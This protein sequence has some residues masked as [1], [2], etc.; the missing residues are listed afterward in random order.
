M[1]TLS[2]S[3]LCFPFVARVLSIPH[4]WT[5]Q[6]VHETIV[7]STSLHFVVSHSLVKLTNKS[8]TVTCILIRHCKFF[9]AQCNLFGRRHFSAVSPQLPVLEAS[10]VKMLLRSWTFRIPLGFRTSPIEDVMGMPC[11]IIRTYNQQGDMRVH[12]QIGDLQPSY[13]HVKWW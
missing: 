5:G 11:D 4:V 7:G 1:R 2:C 10:L 9:I 13:C 12:L 8:C 6:L 3:P